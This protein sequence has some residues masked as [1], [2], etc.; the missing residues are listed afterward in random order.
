MMQKW[1]LITGG[2][3]GIGRAL[4]TGLL[5]QWNVAFTGR[6]EEGVAQTLAQAQAHTDAWVRG[7]CCDG[8]D[9][10][11]VE[12]LAQAMLDE[13][14]PPGAIIHNAGIARDALHIHQDADVWRDVLDNNLIA[15]VSWNKALL[16]AMMTQGEGAIVM[17]SSVTAVKGNSGQTAYAASKAAMMGVAR[18]LAREVGR[19][20]IRVNCLAPGLIES[21]MTAA[22]PQTKLKAMRQEIPLRRLGQMQDV[23]DTAAFLIN[24]GS[25]YLTGQT[26]VLDGGL[27]A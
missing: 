21:D 6:R 9:E 11:R 24:D 14:G 3:R 15:M 16:P 26:L 5:P 19:F 27:S 17:M 13:F 18:S 23:V 20:G 10:Q 8:K 25:R 1:V 4:V 12:E 22:I 7:Y 2:S